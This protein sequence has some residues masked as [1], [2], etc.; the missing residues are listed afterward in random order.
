MTRWLFIAVVLV[1]AAMVCLWMITPVGFV[2]ASTRADGRVLASDGAPLAG[3]TVRLILPSAGETTTT[4]ARGCFHTFRIH[5]P[6]DR[7][8]SLGVTHPGMK[9]WLQKTRGTGELAAEVRLEPLASPAA[10]RGWFR[11]LRESDRA[12]LECREPLEPT[13][14]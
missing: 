5:S 2:D 14:R 1:G 11:G 6:R 4:D 3:A 12:Q 8:A 9:S 13:A 7:R 10:S